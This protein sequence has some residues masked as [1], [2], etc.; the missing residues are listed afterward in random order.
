MKAKRKSPAKK[1]TRSQ[2][3]AEWKRLGRRATR[4]WKQSGGVDP[5]IDRIFLAMD[6][7]SRKLD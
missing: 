2:L 6:Q 4:L 5:E 3:D 1:L 7:L